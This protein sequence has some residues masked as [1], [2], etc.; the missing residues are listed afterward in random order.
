MPA[1]VELRAV[2]DDD[3]PVFFEQQFDPDAIRMTLRG[4]E[5]GYANARGE[6]IAEVLM[7]L[8]EEA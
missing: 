8:T 2:V 3:L 4:E 5:R 6:E 1:A 7:R